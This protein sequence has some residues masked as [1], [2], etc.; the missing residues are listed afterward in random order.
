[1][2]MHVVHHWLHGWSVSGHF[3]SYNEC[4]IFVC[5]L[6]I[7]SSLQLCVSFVKASLFAEFDLRVLV[8]Q[9]RSGR[10]VVWVF[11]AVFHVCWPQALGRVILNL[12]LTPKGQVWV[13]LVVMGGCRGSGRSSGVPGT[14]TSCSGLEL[15]A[16]VWFAEKSSDLLVEQHLGNTMALLWTKA[17]LW[18]PTP[19]ISVSMHRV[20]CCDE[21]KVKYVGVLRVECHVTAIKVK[22]VL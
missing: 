17:F 11:V 20:W 13:P 22:S 1:M 19:S 6:L 12:F 18:C 2:P 21:F 7:V 14:A 3:D 4:I 5:F 10:A 16:F 8:E 15:E 9:L